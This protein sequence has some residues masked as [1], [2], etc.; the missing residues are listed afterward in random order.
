MKNTFD[1]FKKK[2][3]TNV[4]KTEKGKVTKRKRI[5]KKLPEEEQ[6]YSRSCLT[7]EKGNRKIA[8]QEQKKGSSRLLLGGHS[9][10]ATLAAR[11]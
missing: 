4:I 11:T 9:A 3:T 2:V 6:S 1:S 5:K 10:H 7:E 8:T